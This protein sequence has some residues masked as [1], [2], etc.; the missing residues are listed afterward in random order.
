MAAGRLADVFP[1][2]GAGQFPTQLVEG[3]GTAF[4]VEGDASL[5]A[6]IG[7]QRADGQ[8]HRQHNQEGQQIAR[9]GNGE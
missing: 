3:T 1:L 6:Q 2:Q 9:I 7:S 8:R 5:I 4:T